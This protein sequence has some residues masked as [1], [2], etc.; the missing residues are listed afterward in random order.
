MLFYDKAERVLTDLSIEKGFL[1]G[2]K[3][4]GE[5]K[6]ANGDWAPNETLDVK[7]SQGALKALLSDIKKPREGKNDIAN[8][9]LGDG[10]R[11]NIIGSNMIKLRASSSP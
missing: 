10:N 5:L 11:S 7:K 8:K 9:D 1:G 2:V 4:P 6:T 3:L